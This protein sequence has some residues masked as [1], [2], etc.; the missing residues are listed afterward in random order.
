MR[1]Q[2]SRQSDSKSRDIKALPCS[3]LLNFQTIK[4][5][6]THNKQTKICPDRGGEM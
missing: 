1:E 4:I 2:W 5:P 6:Q 3:F